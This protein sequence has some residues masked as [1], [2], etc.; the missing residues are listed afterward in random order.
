MYHTVNFLGN[1]GVGAIVAWAG[2]NKTELYENLMGLRRSTWYLIYA[3]LVLNLIFTIVYTTIPWELL[4]SVSFFPSSSGCWFLSN[5]F[6]KI[7]CSMPGNVAFFA[8]SGLTPT[9]SICFTD[10]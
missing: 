3:V 8:T 6:Q 5:V 4:L 2:F 7:V 9:D 1:F 10:L